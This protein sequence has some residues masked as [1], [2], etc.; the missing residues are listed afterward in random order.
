MASHLRK[1][2]A[3]VRKPTLIALMEWF[4]GKNFQTGSGP[5]LKAEQFAT[6]LGYTDF[7]CTTGWLDQF[8]AGHNICSGRLVA[9]QGLQTLK[10]LTVGS[11]QC[12]LH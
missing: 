12:G 5:I 8:E 7:T 1:G 3:C 11:I 6:M 2:F 4:R 9:K 10:A